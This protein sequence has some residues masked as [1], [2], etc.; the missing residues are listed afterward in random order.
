MAITELELKNLRPKAQPYRV[1][2]GDGLYVFVSPKGTR[3]FRLD[4]RFAGKR[5]T[6]TIGTYPRM[7][8]QQ[9]RVAA[10]LFKN[11]LHLGIDPLDAKRQKK[12]AEKIDER[13]LFKNVAQQWMENSSPVWSP[14][15]FR[16]VQER[17]DKHILPQIG[18]RLITKLTLPELAEVAKKIAKS[19]VDIAHRAASDIKRTLTLAQLNGLIE[20]NPAASINA[21]LPKRKPQEHFP[22]VTDVTTFGELMRSVNNYATFS[23]VRIM[24]QVVARLGMRAGDLRHLT[25][26]SVDF[27]KNWIEITPE[28]TRNSTQVQ[29]IYPLSTQVREMFLQMKEMNGD[30]PCVFFSRNAKKTI[31]YS[32]A[33]MNQALKRLGWPPSVQTIH[34]FRASMKT[35]LIEELGYGE[36]ITELQLGHRVK[37]LH[38]RAYNRVTLLKERVQMMQVWSDFIDCLIQ[39][40][41]Y[42]HLVQK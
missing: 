4:Y 20:H 24:L 12:E 3:T 32:D 41:D 38:G 17:M 29:M 23:D 36:M 22:A 31:Y 42:S 21:A 10:T 18:E 13:L 6:A 34:G 5:L 27:E 28:K 40:R 7:T 14:A 26:D 1:T 8:A 35:L 25:W 33:T 2:D 16:H 11:Q 9:A 15:H 30:K 19:S 37:D 39:R